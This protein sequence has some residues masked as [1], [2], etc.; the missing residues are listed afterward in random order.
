M[1]VRLPEPGAPPACSPL[2]LDTHQ[3]AERLGVSRHTVV[4]ARSYSRAATWLYPTAYRL[5][6][7]CVRY[8]APEVGAV[9]RQRALVGPRGEPGFAESVACS[10]SSRTPSESSG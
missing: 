6:A 2:W 9:A 1:R 8:L 5:G 10:L 3:V 7:R 4:C